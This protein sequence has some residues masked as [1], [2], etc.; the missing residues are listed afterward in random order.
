M[1]QKC[2][3]RTGDS[4]Q[5][6]SRRNTSKKRNYVTLYSSE[7]GCDLTNATYAGVTAQAFNTPEIDGATALKGG[8]KAKR[9]HKSYD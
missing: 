2:I 6:L 3:E 1:T 4:M 8:G 7:G 5:T 9:G